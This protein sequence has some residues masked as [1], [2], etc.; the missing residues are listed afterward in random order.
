MYVLSGTWQLAP[1][2]VVFSRE[3]GHV[4][5]DGTRKSGLRLSISSIPKHNL[6]LISGA[7]DS[8][9]PTQGLYFLRAQRH[10]VGKE[11]LGLVFL[12]P[13]GR[14]STAS[15]YCF[16]IVLPGILLLSTNRPLPKHLYP[17]NYLLYQPVLH[18]GSSI[19]RHTSRDP[20]VAPTRTSRY[21]SRPSSE[22]S[23]T[24]E[25]HPVSAG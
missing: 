9:L 16:G 5:E 17:V 25:V 20:S 3:V 10:T 2:L 19:R 14:R 15:A 13:E 4:L 18:T 7:R 6:Q 21:L 22:S 1:S 11:L 24:V 23:N 8:H 12:F